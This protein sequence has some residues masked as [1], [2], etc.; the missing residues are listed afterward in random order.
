[1]LFPLK[2]AFF[3]FFLSFL[4]ETSLKIIKART[5]FAHSLVHC[6]LLPPGWRVGHVAP[7]R[8]PVAEELGQGGGVGVGGEALLQ[9]VQEGDVR[10]EPMEARKVSLS[11]ASCV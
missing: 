1:M 11:Q 2:Y 6:R 7:V 10:L 8:V 4:Q 5:N 9:V 3:T